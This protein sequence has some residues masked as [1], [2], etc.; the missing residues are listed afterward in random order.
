MI[1]A[2]PIVIKCKKC[3]KEF[4]DF[5]SAHR[6]YC[7]QKCAEG[8][9]IKRGVLNNRYVHGKSGSK[10]MIMRKNLMRKYGITLEQKEHMLRTQNGVCAVCGILIGITGR[11][12]HIDHSHLTGKIRQL[13]CSGCNCGLGNFKE[14]IDALQGAINYLR[15][16][17]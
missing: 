12:S 14:S 1:R 6:K 15:R 7:S 11:D 13:L 17:L 2:K 16:W 10:E 8:V 9:N 4:M 5:A 3:N